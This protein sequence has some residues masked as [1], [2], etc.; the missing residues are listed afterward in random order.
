MHPDHEPSSRDPYWQYDRALGVVTFFG[1][2]SPT[3]MKARLYTEHYQEPAEYNWFR[4][5]GGEGERTYVFMRPY[6]QVSASEAAPRRTPTASHD[7]ELDRLFGL[8]ADEPAPVIERSLGAASASYYPSVRGLLVWEFHLAAPF[9]PN[10][11]A[12]DTT[13][14]ALWQGMED[15]LLDLLPETRFLVTPGWDP[16]YDQDRWERFLVAMDYLPHLMHEE[17]FMKSCA[18]AQPDPPRQRP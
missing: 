11:P 9:R 2:P 15:T 14:Q 5:G 16:E 17:L 13:Y 3:R 18:D 4:R 6:L 10:D 8:A 12:Q 1:H 7:P